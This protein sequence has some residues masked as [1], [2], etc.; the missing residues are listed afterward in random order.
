MCTA[1]TLTGFDTVRSVLSRATEN[2]IPLPALKGG[3][4]VGT[5]VELSPQ[6]RAL[7]LQLL[8]FPDVLDKVIANYEPNHLCGYLFDLAKIFHNF[9][10][11]C[12]VIGSPNQDERLKICLATEVVLFKGLE[13]LNVTALDRV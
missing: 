7:C 9:Y 3:E 10:E 4:V 5:N 1:W 13:L 8:S 6:E 12:R 2:A 11:T